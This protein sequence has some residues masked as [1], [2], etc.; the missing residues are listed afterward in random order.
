[1]SKFLANI[2]RPGSSAFGASASQLSYLAE[3]LRLSSVSDPNVVV[4]FRNLSK[5]D[6]TTKVKALED[7]QIYIASLKEPVEEA[8]LE[9]WVK[10]FP[11]VAIDNARSVRQ[12]AFT[13]QGAMA[14]SG[15]K[16]VAKYMPA[17]VGAWLCGLYDGERMV[18]EAAQA[19]LW[20]IFNTTEKI[21]SI[22][23][24]YQQPILEYC[25]DAIGKES[26]TTLSDERTSSP[27]DAATKYSRVMSACIALL[28]SLLS[29]LSLEDLAKHQADYEVLLGDSKLWAFAS[30]DDASVRRA[31]HR[32]LKSCISKQPN[33]VQTNIETIS[34][35]YLAGALHSD[36]TGSALE[37]LDA[38]VSL[39]Q[40]CPTAWTEHYTSKTPV[41]RRLRQFLK[42]G[43]QSGP[44]EFWNRLVEL[45]KTLPQE[46]LP[47]NGPDAAEL[48]NALHGGIVKKQQVRLDLESALGAYLQITAL[49]SASLPEED[50]RKLLPEL[51]LPAVSQYLDPKPETSQWEAFANAPKLVAQVMVTGQM[52]DLLCEEWPRYVQKLVDDIRTSAP[53]QSSGYETSQASLIHRAGRFSILQQLTLDL[54]S[55]APLR[56]AFEEGCA[57]IVTE[58]I[59]VIKS[60][61]G[62]PYGAAGVI[63][64]L[65]RQNPA[66]V[67]S[68]ERTK[69]T[70]EAFL[71]GDLPTLVLSPS[72]S[73]LVDILYSSA[74]LSGS[75]DS[76]KS[77][78]KNALEADETMA[79][80]TALDAL[81]AS[82][83]IPA[84]F[85]LAASD[86]ELLEHIK[87]KL[88]EALVGSVE[89]D[90]F[91]RILRSLS[92]STTDDILSTMTQSLSLIE[93]TPS[94]L[95]GFRQINKHNPSLMEKFITGSK[96]ADLLQNLLV[97]AENPDDEVAQ[98]AAIFRTMLIS[99]TD[100][101]KSIYNVIQ[102][103]L[104]DASQTSVAVE[105]LI[106]L[107]RQLVTP[108]YSWDEL[109][110]VLPTSGDCESVLKPF[111]ENPPATPLAIT[112]L[113]G[114]AVYLVDSQNHPT[115]LKEISRDADGFSPAFRTAQYIV[116]L[117]SGPDAVN[118]E[119]IPLDRRRDILLNVELT[120]QLAGDNLGLAGANHLWS[121]YTPEVETDVIDFMSKANNFVKQEVQR[122]KLH[123]DVANGDKSFLLWLIR[124]VGD[125]GSNNSANEFYLARACSV[126]AR[127]AIELLGWDKTNDAIV[128]DTLKT[129]RNKTK[130]GADIP[131]LGFLSAFNESLATTKSCER[132]CNELIANLT[133]LDIEAQ[134]EE[135]LRQLVILNGLVYDQEETRNSIA[136]QRAIFFV[137]H[138]IVWLENP[139]VALPIRAEACRVLAALLPL[140]HDI[141][142]DHWESILTSLAA[143]WATSG[144]LHDN[145][146]K[147]TPVP[148]THAS[149]KLYAQLRTLSQD[150]EPND[151]LVDAW[152]SCEEYVANSLVN[153]LKYSQ[154]FPD[155]FHQPLKMVNDVLARQISKV[156][157]KHLAAVDD[158]YPLLYAES[159]SA[160]Q[161][162]FDILRQQIAAA[163][164]QISIDAALDKSTAQLPEELLSLLIEAPTTAAL[165]GASFERH[166]PLPL[167]GY[168]LSWLLVFAHF[169]HASFK[170]KNDY[171]E[172][173]KQG[174]YVASLLDF[175][176]DFLGH[177]RNHAVDMSKLD[178]TT[179]TPDME[180]P[181]RDAE[182]F[183]SHLYFLCLRHISSLTKVWFFN[184]KSRAITTSL[185]SWTEKYISP[186]VIAA[187]MQSVSE[188]VDSLKQEDSES[189]LSVHVAPRARE[190]TAAYDLDE[191]KMIIKITL[192]AAFPLANPTIDSVNRVA[193]SDQKWKSWIR[194]SLGA[195]TVFNGTLIDALTTFKRNIDGAL[196]GHS[197]CYICYSIVSSDKRLP[198]KRCKTC[199]NM[200]HGNCL[201]KWFRTGGSSSCPM[202]RSQF[203]YA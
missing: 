32:F 52:P 22:R 20:N 50:Q 59:G 141:Y 177:T 145:S 182:W 30:Y 114:G 64:E 46:I 161:T 175:T 15:G 198:D 70:L 116:G 103:G 5:K 83:R 12:N 11:R 201:F 27:D 162:A 54:E 115:R 147:S 95:Q 100:S 196:K 9:A 188:W 56:S 158:L 60:R 90:W 142:G 6:G 106:D 40:L 119:T 190:I 88:H 167:R 148:F 48:L 13:L 18:V 186:P 62:K 44:R 26:S 137:K 191:Q 122:Q 185:A 144:D 65:L 153:L 110:Q 39:N 105:T 169:E 87:S 16:R 93:Q 35:A 154:G 174:D 178:I 193:T 203:N 97:A 168:L 104:L 118:L 172:H 146:G 74:E 43:S 53:E 125:R 38:I 199:K 21:Q 150:E 42:K 126:L 91:S 36:Q 85:G 66:L 78:L 181:K 47:M 112:N 187:A 127:D 19:S 152:T 129:I 102:Q 45:F 67:L 132:M 41:E 31:L 49:V 68:N 151:D 77:S 156:S 124:L 72:S 165:E 29:N 183:L 139:E 197:E 99:K 24:F 128:A 10:M 143:S 1:M 113:L 133:G 80:N 111:L 134:P 3:P 173:L 17:S 75:E 120:L 98:E 160:Q 92:P 200:F 131:L 202:C 4:Y 51:L 8:V 57:A 82:P 63:A 84:S 166:M 164:V 14:S 37:F 192:P 121:I 86:S 108:G 94:A 81:L 135:G 171:V 176:F 61:N 184:C 155:E 28:A 71:R 55:S 159:G 163:Q 179:Y 194:T 117:L 101:K 89:W 76:W 7:L 69:A 96:G 58:A 157:Q 140:I 149:L 34:K 79:K 180:P 109:S 23:K 25:R 73:N 123:W 189:R 2:G 107:A 138:I 195:I 33:A 170:V 136:K 130:D